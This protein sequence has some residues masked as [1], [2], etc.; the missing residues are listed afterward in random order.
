[1]QNYGSFDFEVFSICPNE[2][3]LSDADGFVSS[4]DLYLAERHA[5]FASGKISLEAK[6]QF[7]LRFLVAVPVMPLTF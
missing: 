5:P 3:N 7:L 2:A 1:L 6:L 4:P